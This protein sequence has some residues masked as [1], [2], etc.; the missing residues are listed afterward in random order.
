MRLIQKEQTVYNSKRRQPAEQKIQIEDTLRKIEALF[1]RESW[2]VCLD[3]RDE[4]DHRSMLHSLGPKN[5]YGRIDRIT[6][7][8]YVDFRTDLFAMFVHQCIH[9]VYPL[10]IERD[11]TILEMIMVEYMTRDQVV[12][13][14]QLLLDNSIHQLVDHPPL[15]KTDI[16]SRIE[17]LFDGGQW[18]VSL[19]QL[20]GET[21]LSIIRNLG[22]NCHGL[23]DENILILYVDFRENLVSLFIH[24]CLHAIYPQMSEDDV[25]KKEAATISRL[26]AP[27]AEYLLR[28]MLKYRY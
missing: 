27:Q 23:V 28:L 10:M 15:V 20:R 18:L 14:L 12:R 7:V 5:S 3:W 26:D 16:I 2:L 6:N 22:R 21:D 4:S 25:R 11:T 24:E 13:M 19:D 17:R 8:I 1:R 9:A